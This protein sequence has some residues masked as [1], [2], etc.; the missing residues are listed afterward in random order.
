MNPNE[1]TFNKISRKSGRKIS[2]CKCQ[3]CKKQCTAP[4]LGTPEDIEKLID[5]G[6]KDKILE[7]TWLAGMMM[8]AVDH[9]IEMYQ[10]EHRTDTG[11]CTFF[12]DGLCQLHDLG[13][14]PTEGKLSHHSLKAE[15]WTASKSVS[16][17]VAK[18]WENPKNKEIINRIIEKLP[19]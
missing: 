12:K 2:F 5:A 11:F 13:L 3:Q 16:I 18:E 10:A 19:R 9:P 1:S 7:T 4:C 17:L 15:N 8:G 6:Y 14:K